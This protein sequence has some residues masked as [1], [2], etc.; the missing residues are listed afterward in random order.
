[1]AGSMERRK[2]PS[3]W[4]YCW[5]WK[6]FSIDIYARANFKDAFFPLFICYFIS[7][8]SS[9]AN[10]ITVHLWMLCC[11]REDPKKRFKARRCHFGCV[12]CARV[13]FL[14]RAYCNKRRLDDPVQMLH[15]TTF[16]HCI[17]FWILL[18]LINVNAYLLRVKYDLLYL[19]LL[20][21]F[22]YFG[23]YSSTQHVK[24]EKDI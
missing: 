9:V 10:A 7:Q 15:W 19:L 1:M 23:I 5:W 16:F 14:V 13:F 21:I 18:F 17:P 8:K 4:I 20:G 11:V 6:R 12:K 24:L 2:E 22:W 3:M